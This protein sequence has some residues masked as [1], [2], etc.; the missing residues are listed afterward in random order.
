MRIEAH[1]KPALSEWHGT[2]GWHPLL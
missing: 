2:T 1:L